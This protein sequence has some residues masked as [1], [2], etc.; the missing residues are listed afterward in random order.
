MGLLAYP[1]GRVGGDA[2]RPE[3]VV[4][5][6]L[7]DDH[8]VVTAAHLAVISVVQVDALQ[9][10]PCQR[11]RQRQQRRQGQKGVPPHVRLVLEIGKEE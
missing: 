5:A 1:D 8:E 6:V 2:G 4:G 9:L 10:S 7:R 11:M 3:G